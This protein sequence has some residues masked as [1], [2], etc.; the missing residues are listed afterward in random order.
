MYRKALI[1]TAAGVLIWGLYKLTNE[2][3][4]RAS[5]EDNLV[6]I[7]DFSHG[8]HRQA[9]PAL[10]EARDAFDE[11]MRDVIKSQRKAA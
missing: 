8:R 6:Y 2:A 7:D 10:E 4:Q 9:R 3:A 11:R 1:G 5:I